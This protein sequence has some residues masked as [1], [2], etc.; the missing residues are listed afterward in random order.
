MNP[1]VKL[2]PELDLMLDR[3]VPITPEQAFAGWTQ[4]ELIIQWFTPKPWRTPEARVDL[5]PG[6]EFYTRMEGPDGESFDGTGCWLEI[7][8]NSRIVWTSA[9]G[10]EF[11]PVMVS[12]DLPFT[13]T[14]T[15]MFDPVPEGT[16]YRVVL[17]HCTPEARAQHDE[18][19]FTSGWG[20]ALDQLVELMQSR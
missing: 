19:G 6:G 12:E 17:R 5:R 20:A 8:P 3:V 16:R 14:A 2:N 18:M 10:P 11:R 4:P 13:F 1:E 7:V 15:V 9:L